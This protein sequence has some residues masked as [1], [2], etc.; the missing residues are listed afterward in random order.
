MSFSFLNSLKTANIF[1]VKERP[2]G[3]SEV[4]SPYTT[5]RGNDQIF[6][7]IIFVIKNTSKKKFRDTGGFTILKLVLTVS[8]QHS[9]PKKLAVHYQYDDRECSIS[10]LG[11]ACG[12]LPQKREPANADWRYVKAHVNGGSVHSSDLWYGKLYLWLCSN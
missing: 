8:Y 11:A 9:F 10:H 7:L 12:F 4:F 2:E 6:N 5:Q 1:K 3:I